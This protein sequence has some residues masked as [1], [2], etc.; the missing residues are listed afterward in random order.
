MKSK[1]QAGHVSI[2]IKSS[3]EDDNKA[4]YMVIE[5]SYESGLGIMK[6]TNLVFHNEEEITNFFRCVSKLDY[7]IVK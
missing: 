1:I 5:N 6:T 4:V 3:D 2:E 7:R